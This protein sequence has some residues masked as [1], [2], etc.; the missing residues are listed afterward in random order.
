MERGVGGGER[1]FA[2]KPKSNRSQ[3]LGK[4]KKFPRQLGKKKNIEK[5][6]TG[7]KGP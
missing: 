2:S 6:V 4:K 3:P 5:S 7:G 1:D